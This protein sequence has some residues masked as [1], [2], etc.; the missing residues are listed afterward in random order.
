M[1]L[2]AERV[3]HVMSVLVLN[4]SFEGVFQRIPIIGITVYKVN[5]VHSR[6]IALGKMLPGDKK[7]IDIMMHVMCDEYNENS[8]WF[9]ER[10]NRTRTR[11]EQS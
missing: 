2:C 8:S 10:E 3:H 1:P 7:K 4:Q 6:P 11:V 9:N 5:I